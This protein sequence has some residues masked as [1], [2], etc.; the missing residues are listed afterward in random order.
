MLP[1]WLFFDGCFSWVLSLIKIEIGGLFSIEGV[2]GGF[3]LVL[4]VLFSFC[5]YFVRLCIV[6][7]FFLLNNILFGLQH[8]TEAALNHVEFSMHHFL[9]CFC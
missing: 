1:V 5:G 3:P 2:V 6:S 4:C 7:S 8:F 9:I